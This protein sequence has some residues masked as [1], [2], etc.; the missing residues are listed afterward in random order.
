MLLCSINVFSVAGQ[1]PSA[2]GRDRTAYAGDFAVPSAMAIPGKANA[3]PEVA[4]A[5]KNRLAAA[6]AHVYTPL[7]P[8]TFSQ[9]VQVQHHL[10]AKY[11]V[12]LHSLGRLCRAWARIATQ[13]TLHNIIAYIRYLSYCHCSA[14]APHTHKIMASHKQ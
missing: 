4:A 3:L 1:K 7:S 9:S 12:W 14:S 8:A 5:T 2:A 11:G 13:L 6:C 10:Y